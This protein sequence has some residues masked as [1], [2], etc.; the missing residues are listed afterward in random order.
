MGAGCVVVAPNIKN[1][2]EIILN[3]LNGI[4]YDKSYDDLLNIVITLLSKS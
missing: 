1:N 3:N 4:L 2:S